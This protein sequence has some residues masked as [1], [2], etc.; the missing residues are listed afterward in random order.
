MFS[1]RIRDAATGIAGGLS[2]SLL[3]VAQAQAAS[4]Q[5]FPVKP[6]L[7]PMV[8]AAAFVMPALMAAVWSVVKRWSR[9]VHPVLGVGVLATLVAVV[10]AVSR[11]ELLSALRI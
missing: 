1:G 7:V 2:V 10:L 9:Q 5:L 4:G 11:P 3:F 8:V 6:S